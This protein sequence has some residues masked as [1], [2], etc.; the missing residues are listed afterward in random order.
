M[1]LFW[2]R[3]PDPE[4]VIR[5]LGKAG[6]GVGLRKGGIEEVDFISFLKDCKDGGNGNWDAKKVEAERI[7]DVL[8]LVSWLTN[9]VSRIT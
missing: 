4:A 1:S 6:D 2:G 5:T 8:S 3:R 9:R 7:A